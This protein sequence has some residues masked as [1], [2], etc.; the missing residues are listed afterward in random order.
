MTGGDYAKLR[1]WGLAELKPNDDDPSKKDSGLWRPTEKGRR[2][3][4]R[5]IRVPRYVYLYKNKVMGFSEETISIEE[6]LKVSFDYDDLMQA[7]LADMEDL[8]SEVLK[9]E[10]EE[11]ERRK[12]D[13]LKRKKENDNA[14]T[15]H[16]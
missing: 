5:Q 2:F 11:K 16:P 9:K 4:Y 1:H 3:A 15:Q 10:D 14:S 6:A 13:E 7:G 8:I 12:K